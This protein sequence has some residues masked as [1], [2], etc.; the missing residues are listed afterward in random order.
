MALIQ[1]TQIE[2]ADYLGCSTMTL[3]KDDQFNDI[4][5]KGMSKGRMSLRRKQ[6]AALEA[7]NNTMLIWLGK[8]YLGQQDKHEHTG[9]DNGPIQTQVTFV[10]VTAKN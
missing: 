7:G 3:Q 5:K 4:Y 10:G 2:I 8:Q 1:C 6:W 9:K